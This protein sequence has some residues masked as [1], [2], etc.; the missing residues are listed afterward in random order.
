MEIRPILSALMRNKTGGLLVAIQVALSLAILANALYVV[1]LRMTVMQ[2]SSGI[3]DEA[4]VFMITSEPVTAASHIEQMAQQQRESSTLRGLAGVLAVAKVN[5]VPLSRS[6]WTAGYAT[7]RRQTQ[8]VASAAVYTTPDSLVS[9]W[10]LRLVAGRDFGPDDVMEDD[11]S[12]NNTIPRTIMV[13]R[14]LAEKAYPG[15]S[16]IGKE[17]LQGA[18]DTALS[19]R[20]IGVVD[21]L[22]TPAA[23]ISQNGEYAV[24]MPMRSSGPSTV[25]TVHAEPGQRDRLMGEAAAALRR[26][27]PTPTIITVQSMDEV[28]Q[29]RYS[30]DKAL[31]WTLIAVSA[32]LLL[33]TASGIV[34]IASLWVTQRR[35]QIGVRRALGARRIDILRYFLTE[36]VMITSAGVLAGVL[37]GLALNQLLV[38]QLEMSRLPPGY[39]VAGAALFWVLGIAAVYGPAWRAASISPAT[40]TRGA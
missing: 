24:I 1:Q 30:A 4:G 2:R 40:A 14:A 5:Q 38:S 3:A 15:T 26:I 19:A 28:R 18:G 36:N 11:P 25:Y 7:D 37:L 34:G 21:R 33:V 12:V 31:A 39:L 6:G 8:T 27:A 17:L 29:K 23:Q 13:T 20:I 9:T 35:K 10:G 22:Q 16:A 32:L